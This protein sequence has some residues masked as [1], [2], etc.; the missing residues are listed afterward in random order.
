MVR[1]GMVKPEWCVLMQGN[2]EFNC[3]SN[4]FTVTSG[5]IGTALCYLASR[6]VSTATTRE[7]TFCL[8]SNSFQTQLLYLTLFCSEEELWQ[9]GFHQH[10]FHGNI[11]KPRR[12]QMSDHVLVSTSC[13]WYYTAC[14]LV[15]ILARIYCKS[16]RVVEYSQLHIILA[17]QY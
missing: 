13:P 2:E 6:F 4:T 3:R 12:I 9:F 14:Q 5:T 16:T 15:A 10:M 1:H 8:Q 17:S 11:G 7:V